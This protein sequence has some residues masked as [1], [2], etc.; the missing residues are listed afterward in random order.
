M[1]FK[2]FNGNHLYKLVLLPLVGVALLASSFFDGS[3]V[4]TPVEKITSPICLLQQALQMNA[5]G[6]ITINFLIGT[7]IVSLLLKTN[8]D[9]KLVDNR[10]YLPGFLYL[11]I[12]YAFPQLHFCQPV[13]FAAIFFVLS[14]RSLFHI[15]AK[16][17]IATDV[18]NAA[19]F[20][21][22]GS[23]FYLPLV[24]FLI[25]IPVSVILVR[26]QILFKELVASL[27]GYVLPWLLVFA[28][29]FVFFDVS[30]LQ[31]MWVN[32]FDSSNALVINSNYFY[33]Y[34][35]ILV[36]MTVASSA[37]MFLQFDREK[38]ATRNYNKILFSF[39]IGLI[40][41]LAL[42]LVQYEMIVLAAIPLV[43]LIS[44]YLTDL[45]SNFW[46][47]VFVTIIVAVSVT[48]Q[49]LF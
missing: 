20:L 22:L 25:L 42:P 24:L 27:I 14:I 6:S 40:I 1:L 35:G 5:K 49:Y 19:F 9:F 48:M 38:V 41:S 47:E 13:F 32:S 26:K 12:V 21:G 10:N 17:K 45:R 29:Y 39:F 23:V 28:V 4:F 31:E 30:Q 18:F 2:L 43:F 8:S 37:Y 44:N 7:L 46:R 36:F 33:V 3:L 15:I 11:V 16:K 34:L